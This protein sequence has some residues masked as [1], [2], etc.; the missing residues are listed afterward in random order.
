MAH[1]VHAIFVQ[2]D[3]AGDEIRIKIRVAGT[4]DQLGQIAPNEWFASG[5]TNLQNA[6]LGSFTQDALPVGSG[7]F[8]R[9]SE[10]LRI[11]AVRTMKRTSIS[12]LRQ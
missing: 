11:R 4:A 8:A 7:Q 1:F 10:L 6:E 12:D 5:E 2:T 9:S 3:A